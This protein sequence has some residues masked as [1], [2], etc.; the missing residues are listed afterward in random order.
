MLKGQSVDQ[1]LLVFR[2]FRERHAR[3][4]PL[5]NS[6]REAVREV[7]ERYSVT[8][9]TIGDGC[10]RRLQLN[11]IDELYALLEQWVEGNPEPLAKQLKRASDHSA[12]D[13]IMRF[14][15]SSTS[16]AKVTPRQ[17]ASATS[18]GKFDTFSFSLSERNARMLR[19]LAEISGVS[20]REMVNQLVGAAL[21]EKMKLVAQEIIR[22]SEN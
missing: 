18:K 20:T 7:A 5:H 12:H 1:L 6:Y 15:E 19:A 14:F 4:E 9:Q 11:N 3:G 2:K 21:A 8:Y 13:N 17:V 16:S 22:D 10:R